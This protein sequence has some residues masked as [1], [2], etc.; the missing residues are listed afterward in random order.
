MSQ[1]L[2]DHHRR[3][4]DLELAFEALRRVVFVNPGHELALQSA[5]HTLKARGAKGAAELLVGDRASAPY[6]R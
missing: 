6:R 5:V 1:S 4:E 2:W 3:L